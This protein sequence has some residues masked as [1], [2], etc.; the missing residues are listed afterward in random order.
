[1]TWY[2]H[3]AA[4]TELFEAAAYYDSMQNGLGYRF[5]QAFETAVLDI[6]AFPSSWFEVAP[7]IRRC[8]IPH[9]PFGIMYRIFGSEMQIVAVADLRR[10]PGY[11]SSRI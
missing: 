5:I 3:P 1:M 11:W 8:L 10:K 6:V 4:R 9:F 2:F 7:G